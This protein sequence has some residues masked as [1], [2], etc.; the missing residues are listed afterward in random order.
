MSPNCSSVSLDT[1]FLDFQSFKFSSP[2]SAHRAHVKRPQPREVR[3]PFHC[4][5]RPVR[6]VR[7]IQ[8]Q[9]DG[10]RARGHACRD[11]GRHREPQGDPDGPR[12]HGRDK[13]APRV[14]FFF[15]DNLTSPITNHSLLVPSA[16]QTGVEAHVK[17]FRGQLTG[18]EVQ[19]MFKEVR[20]YS[21]LQNSTAYTISC[22]SRNSATRR[23]TSRR[24]SRNC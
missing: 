3:P 24:R 15:C 4:A 21:P 8:A 2:Y 12:H 17:D 9:Q 10:R 14:R 13:E 16:V 22:R 20:S 18:E 23:R 5:P 6:Q 7:R 19:L 1:P 11:R